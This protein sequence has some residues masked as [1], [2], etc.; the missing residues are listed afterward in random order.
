MILIFSYLFQCPLSIWATWYL[1]PLENAATGIFC[2]QV[3]PLQFHETCPHWQQV[4]GFHLWARGLWQMDMNAKFGFG[5]SSGIEQFEIESNAGL[6]YWIFSSA[7]LATEVGLI[8][9]WDPC[10]PDVWLKY[11]RSD[12]NLGKNHFQTK[13]KLDVTEELPGEATERLEETQFKHTWTGE[14]LSFPSSCW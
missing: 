8:Q 2:R 7:T 3:F 9:S 1:L 14:I 10:W 6:F 11:C 12:T 5:F 4:T 13:S